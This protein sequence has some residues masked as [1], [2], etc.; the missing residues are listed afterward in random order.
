MQNMTAWT[1]RK[2]PMR[3]GVRL[4]MRRPRSAGIGGARERGGGPLAPA[5]SLS[6]NWPWFIPSSR[7]V[8]DC[9]VVG[10]V[11]RNDLPGKLRLRLASG[12]ESAD[13]GAQ[14]DDTSAQASKCN[15]GVLKAIGRNYRVEGSCG[16]AV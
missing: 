11:A 12:G 1:G 8:E 15:H 9:P 6:R 2:P 13:Q 4:R 14:N 5:S 7:P 10:A 16:C 3:P